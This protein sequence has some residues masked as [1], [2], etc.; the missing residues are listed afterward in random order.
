MLSSH[1]HEKRFF[2]DFA[3]DFAYAAGT[4]ARNSTLT[5]PPAVT[6]ITAIDRVF[7]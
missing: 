1:R 5:L 3:E 7:L 2:P 6:A 4:V